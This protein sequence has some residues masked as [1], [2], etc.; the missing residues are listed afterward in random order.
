M[1]I[2]A[3]IG[4]PRKGSNTELL[5]WPYRKDEASYRSDEALRC[6]QKIKGQEMGGCIAISRRATFLQASGRNASSFM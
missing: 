5:V 3:L 1:K 6:K 4:S 2:L